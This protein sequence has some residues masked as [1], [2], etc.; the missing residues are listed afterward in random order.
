M[1]ENQKPISRP[2]SQSRAHPETQARQDSAKSPSTPGPAVVLA[3]LELNPGAAVNFGEVSNT[4]EPPKATVNPKPQHR[5]DDANLQEPAT[6]P[7]GQ[8]YVGIKQISSEVIVE[9]T[10]KGSNAGLDQASH[11]PLH[12]IFKN[13]ERYCITAICSFLAIFSSISVPIYLPALPDIEDAFHVTT[14]QVNLTIV[15]Y[16]IFQGL[17]PAFWC[18]LA[19]KIGR[20]PVYVQCL[21][22][23]ISACIGLALAPSY[24]VLLG[25][26]ALQAAGMA[27]S[28]ALGS[29]VVGDITLRRDRG[30]FMGIFS[31]I[32]L[33]GNAIGP[34]IGGGLTVAFGWRSIFWF[35]VILA[36]SALVLVIVAFPET[37]RFIVGN[38]LVKPKHF[39][40]QAPSMI[41][42]GKLVPRQKQVPASYDPGVTLLA[43]PPQNTSVLRTFRIL[44]YKDVALLLTPVGLHYASWF[45]AL[46]AQSTLLESNYNFTLFQIG[47]SYLANGIGSVFGSLFSGKLTDY[48]YRK[49]VKKF[50]ADW[51]SQY[52]P[53]VPVNMNKFDIQK[54]RLKPSFA[55]SSVVVSTTI[56]F[57]WS[58]QY[59]VHWIV[60]IRASVSWS[61][62]FPTQAP[63]VQSMSYEACS[64]L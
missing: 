60:P 25:M 35:L 3:P 61:T 43:T 8:E 26:R 11:D 7:E 5:H 54:A 14:E 9:P 38:G 30:S 46:T 42:R 17:A 59:K 1:S 19:D 29:G 62:C 22:V 6:A 41:L 34:L 27:T 37:A 44:C 57:G 21:I 50:Q 52:G 64:V 53:D 63:L 13:W 10:E 36:G 28:L 39:W 31:G 47:L 45:M 32:F 40:N 15:T 18:P 23:Y 2:V 20:K 58:I 24:G 49:E 51:L 4:S 56:V 12:T 55:I 16:C 33:V 48:F